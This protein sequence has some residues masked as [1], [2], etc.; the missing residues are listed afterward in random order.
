MTAIIDITELNGGVNGTVK[1]TDIYPAVDV[2]DTTQAP[3][4]TTKRYSISQLVTFI[5][6]GLPTVGAANTIIIS[7]GTSWVSSTSLWPN[8]VGTSGKIL[9]SNGTNN[10]Y[11]TPTYPNSSVTS[12]K[13]IISNGTNFIAST[14][15]YPNTSGTSGQVLISDGTNIVYGT[16]TFP[17]TT[18]INQLLWSPSA[19]TVT[20]L[21]TANN[22]TLVTSN[23]GVPSILAGPGTTG[24]VLQSN[25]AAAPSFST[26][27]YPST[28]TI[29][30]ILYS[31][32]SN[33]VAGLSTAASGALITSAGGV[34][35]ISQTLP[36]AV[37]GNI[38]A[39]GTIASG[40]WNG[41][42]IPGQYGGTGVANTGK[43]ITLAG[44]FTTTG[45]FN[46]TF[47]FSAS[48]TYTYPSGS[49]T[50]LGL[51]GGTMTGALLLNTSAP[52]TALQAA[53][54]G[55]VDSIAS[56]FTIIAAAKVATTANL[57][58][59]YANGA[60]GVG[61]TLTAPGVGILTIDG[62]ATVLNDRILAK[63][64]TTTFQNGV[65][66]VST[67]GTAGVA[68]ILTRVTDYDSAA[69][70]K[71]GSIVPVTSG[72]TLASSSW[73]QYDTVVTVGTDAIQF[74]QYSVSYPISLANGGTNATLV[75]SAGSVVYSTASAFAFSAVG[76]S[77]QIFQSTGTTAPGW[78]TATY[79]STTTV[80]Q[81]LYSSSSNVVAGIT[82]AA[83]SVLVT[84]A[85]SIPSLSTDIPTAVTI[86][87]AYIYRVGGTDVALLDGG[88]NAS[89]VASNGGIFYSTATAGAILSGTATAGKVLQSGATAA[90]TWSTPTYPSASGSAGKIIRSDGTNNV[91]TTAT[92]ADTYAVSTLLYASSGNAVSG[93]ATVVSSILSTDIA[94][95]PTWL[96]NV[97]VPLGGTGVGMFTAYSVVCG[98]TTATG[99]LQNVSGLG[100]AGQILTSN[101]ASA[102]P[103]WQSAS[104]SNAITQIFVQTFT[105]PGAATYTRTSGMRYAMIELQADGGGSGGTT[106]GA[107][108]AALSGAGGG[109]GYLK[110][111][112]T[113]A[114]IGVS[115]AVNVGAGGA[116]G[117][118]GNN[119]GGAGT[120]TTI[121]IGGSTWTAGGGGLGLGQACSN[122][123]QQGAN[124]GAGGTNTTGSNALLIANIPG[125]QGEFGFTQANAALVVRTL[126]AGGGSILAPFNGSGGGANGNNYGGGASAYYNATGSN[127]PGNTGAQGIIIITEYISV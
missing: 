38:T 50:L 74:T 28:T 32:S 2:T 123:A 106:G 55:Y 94:G 18:T 6:G 62:V 115:C 63:N 29:S 87:G 23:T 91:Y 96:S 105:T 4:G 127:Q 76:S 14:P 1:N 73:L 107:S 118:S 53:S 12:G 49:D 64:Q 42:V 122:S 109:G 69:E 68:A 126:P 104:G 103:S 9:I 13:L 125:G 108:Q 102:L 101:G 46:P 121:T 54:K 81:I 20:G 120:G 57:A 30:Q 98:G 36:S 119:N 11:S 97:T 65:Y 16:S 82:A 89:L 114:N 83:S 72:T 110:L 60:A 124:P 85:G 3:T 99:A 79:P 5:G 39:L 93:L 116:A 27:I 37:Q 66:Y 48:S 26:A 19:N 24:N 41:T 95:I 88:T 59:T 67:E 40:V 47:A 78:T 44:N 52:S 25:A 90:P 58:Y 22:G 86:G 34:P 17:I 117:V 35:S 80:N 21:A 8:T 84:S 92:F 56:G 43:T 51:A 111:Y 77:G 71:V 7:N 33:V 70:I 100:V 10:V 15:T 112:A 61:A 31:S 45:A 75:A 113:A